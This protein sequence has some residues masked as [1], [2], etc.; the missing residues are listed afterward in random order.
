MRQLLAQF[1]LS[2]VDRNM[3]KG[4]EM[5]LHNRAGSVLLA[6]AACI[7][8]APSTM[9]QDQSG[10]V[11]PSGKEDG[12]KDRNTQAVPAQEIIVTGS[13]IKGGVVASEVTVLDR[14]ALVGVGNIDLG[15]AIR[16]LPQNFSGGQN[17]GVGFGAGL[18]NSNVN[19][20]SSANLR[21]L[22]PD[23]TLTLLNGHR[24]PYD[25]ASAGVDIS[26]IPLAA[27]DRIE[28]VPDGASALYGSDA[29]AGVVNV[30]LRRNFSGVTTSGQLGAATDG[31][32]FRQQADIVAGESWD[33]GGVLL[34]YDYMHNA[35]IAAR[36]RDYAASLDPDTSL[37]PSQ[38][39]HAITLSA[40]QDL[41][42][43]VSASIDA[44]Y[45][46]RRSQ[47][48]SG[49]Q[50]ARYLSQPEVE[51]Y[52]FAPSLQFPLAG[53]WEA[54]VLGVYGRDDTDY[55]TTFTPGT[56]T[57]T[58]TAG[59][60]CNSMTAFEGGAE[61]PLFRLPG[62]LARLAIGGGLRN[63]GLEYIR[64][65]N[66]AASASFDVTRRSRYAYGELY[67]PFVSPD[68]EL[69]GIERLSLSAA[70]R[71]ENYPGLD[72]LVTPR[73]G[74]IYAPVPGLLVRGTWARSF[75]APTLYQ[76]YIPY[77]TYLLPASS[78]GAGTGTST[79][80]YASGGNPG[81]KPE[82]SESW[83]AGF[84]AKPLAIRELTVSATWFDIRYQDRVVQP[85][86]GSIAAA[87]QDPGYA[88]LLDFSPE[89]DALAELI[90][91]AQL[92]LQN[93]SGYAY[94]PANVTAYV[95]NR[96]INVAV[97][98]IRGIDAT[99]AWESR[100]GGEQKLAFVMAGSWL[101][102]SQQLTRDLPS[103]KLA[104]T[105]FNPPNFRLRGTAQY[106]DNALR[107]SSSL[108][109]VGAMTD[110]RFDPAQ[111][112]APAAT[113]DVSAQ[114]MIIPGSG[115]EP[116]LA[117]SLTVNNIFNGKPDVIRTTG[118]NDTPYD[119][120]NYSPIGRFMAIG[121]RRHW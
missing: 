111:R 15:E 83:T 37:Y 40:H 65:I 4:I 64:T 79:V 20:T 59:C 22:G 82:R 74:L 10:T 2:Q 53:G 104:G 75:K 9:A 76:Q 107:L 54:K 29:V 50:Q 47:T 102:S 12:E 11:I 91:G 112:L 105:V 119:S 110:S 117:V 34:A 55:S 5:K 81:L 63:N 118:P 67:L 25:S 94:D 56:G 41:G 32:Y 35:R 31:G 60:F 115:G 48:V 13:H 24:L 28:V 27:L 51:S 87:F 30:I 109:F 84:E 46:R 39:R 71:Y 68:T 114:Y 49:T 1:G 80:L 77:Q 21:G 61:G 38:E 99:I 113:F 101:R 93:Y 23:A 14:E 85:I 42:H 86:A 69:R 98:A 97:Q 78:F 26:A 95:D 88:T 7:A 73:L 100:L 6:G 57:P 70:L 116:G 90:A 62:G 106:Q 89:A 66:S 19:S 58:V 8:L 33:S 43:G 121:F 72:R 120:T 36:Q 3:N 103:V 92:S 18:V 108:N 44:L 16:A 17:P 96:N 52:T 45:S